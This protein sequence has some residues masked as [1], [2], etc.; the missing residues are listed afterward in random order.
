M[1]GREPWATASVGGGGSNL[2]APMGHSPLL[3]Q[4]PPPDHSLLLS[5]VLRVISGPIRLYHSFVV[6]IG[7]I[8]CTVLVNI[9]FYL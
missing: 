1:V 8:H 5:A 9:K 6:Y 7:T 2:H 3:D 4:P